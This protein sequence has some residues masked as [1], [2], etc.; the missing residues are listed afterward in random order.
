[1]LTSRHAFWKPLWLTRASYRDI[2][3]ACIFLNLLGISLPIFTRVV[4]DRVI[5]NFAQATLWVLFSGM[6]LVLAFEVL[7]KLS[8]SYITDR[9]GNIAG[10]KLEQQFHQHLM[11]LPHG[12]SIAKTG[13][14]FNYLQ[15][16][17]DFF[18]Q[19]LVPTLID[20]PFVL[21][22]LLA[23]FLI[24]P[25]MS[26]VP[27][28]MGGIII[29]LQY[30]FHIALH[31]GLL[32]NQQALYAKQSV[33]VETMH[34]RETIRQ[35]T[36]YSTFTKAW[37]SVTETAAI[38]Q[39]NLLFWQGLVAHLCTGAV[40][41]N[42]V[43]LIM[44]GVYEIHETRLSVGG[45]LAINLLSARALSPLTSIGSILAKWPHLLTEMDTIEKVLSL[46]VENA[47][48]GEPFVLKGAL[49]MKDAH[50]QYHPHSQ[51]VL[52][53]VALHLQQGQKLALVGASG[54]GKS[55][56]LKV[57]SAEL[58]LNSGSMFWDERDVQ[59]ITPVNLRSQL[60]IVDQYPYFFA[61]SLR[62]N[63]L[64]GL[65]REDAEIRHALE[66]VGMDQFVKAMGHGLELFISEG[67]LN[68]SGGQRQCFAIARALLRQS[69]VL[70]MD[71]PTS[72]MDHHMELR[73]VDNLTFAIKEKT[74][75]LAT[76]RSPLLKLA[77]TL[78]VME[79]GKI[80][81]HGKR[82]DVIRELSKHDAR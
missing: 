15:E 48:D 72:M 42:S 7:F 24:C 37:E 62:E 22:F 65:E 56:L 54:A 39:S 8:R 79:N 71:E 58:P 19:K 29:G 36:C 55:T 52:K 45:L 74:V 78:V 9:L 33:L 67:G 5:P 53:D 25:A 49:V 77:D 81:R 40:V 41:L 31:K 66:I 6:I 18:C 32:S 16:I 17:R 35:L 46:P 3:V 51:P 44:V 82:D 20:A 34:G 26:I 43:L 23:I 30:A 38:S 28:V 60:G 4:Y 10:A 47:A 14:Y 73:L 69:P 27:I 76:H 2:A 57:L 1:M 75:I 12:Y 21:T 64:M 59:N 61:R 80:T 11:H 70:I 50:V 13:Q 68:L 63:L